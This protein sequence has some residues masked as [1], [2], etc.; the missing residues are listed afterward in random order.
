MGHDK[1]ILNFLPLVSV[2]TLEHTQELVLM[3]NE[4]KKQAMLDQR[5]KRQWMENRQY[6][7]ARWEKRTS[8]RGWLYQKVSHIY[9]LLN[10]YTHAYVCTTTHLVFAM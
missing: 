8:G 9:L 1:S 4:R 10:Y 7:L 6:Q 5:K 2:S 3:D